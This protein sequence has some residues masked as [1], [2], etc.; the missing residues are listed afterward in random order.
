MGR[1]RLSSDH[2]AP[3]FRQLG[4]R[5]VKAQVRYRR[6]WWRWAR[7]CEASAC[8]SASE[9]GFVLWLRSLRCHARADGLLSARHEAKISP[10]ACVDR[11]TDVRIRG[12]PNCSSQLITSASVL[13]TDHT[14]ESCG[15]GSFGRRGTHSSWQ[16]TWLP[17]QNNSTK[18][19]SFDSCLNCYVV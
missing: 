8:C 14:A 5:E 16:S 9:H 2:V 7:Y 6:S 19:A 17:K 15:C 10:T 12:G 11:H 3:V 1:E 13:A 4:E 18:P